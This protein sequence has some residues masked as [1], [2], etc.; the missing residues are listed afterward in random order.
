MNSL[1][2]FKRI[3]IVFSDY[4]IQEPMNES[5]SSHCFCF[6]KDCQTVIGL[7]FIKSFKKLCFTG[8]YV[9]MV[10]LRLPKQASHRMF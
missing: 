3:H 4:R 9:Y 6:G 1:Q 5:L 2:S 10:D 8:A 7:A